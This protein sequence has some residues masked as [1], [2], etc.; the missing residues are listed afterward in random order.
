[1]AIKSVG[2]LRGA[3]EKILSVMQ[4][5]SRDLQIT[6]SSYNESLKSWTVFANFSTNGNNYGIF[7]TFDEDGNCTKYD[8]SKYSY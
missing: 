5:D 4:Q 7:L 8:L 3:V 1:M 6:Y 2:D